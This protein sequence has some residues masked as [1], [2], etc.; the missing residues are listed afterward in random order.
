MSLSNT[1]WNI[2]GKGNNEQ[3]LKLL[4]D[5]IKCS[6]KVLFDTSIFGY[7]CLE[8]S[9][10]HGYFMYTKIILENKHCTS[11]F[12]LHKGRY[13]QNALMISCERGQY[14]CAKAIIE[15]KHC[16]NNIFWEVDSIG[17]NCLMTTLINKNMKIANLI[18]E[19]LQYR[20]I[21]N[22]MMWKQKN[23]QELDILT[24][25]SNIQEISK[26]WKE[27]IEYIYHIDPNPLFQ[28]EEKKRNDIYF[29]EI[30][31]FQKLNQRIQKM[32]FE[33]INNKEKINQKLQRI[34]M[35]LKNEIDQYQTQFNLFQLENEE[36]TKYFEIEKEEYILLFGKKLNDINEI[37]AK[38]HK[39]TKGLN[40]KNACILCYD[41]EKDIVLLPCSH[42]AI[43]RQC[44]QF[45]ND[46]CPIC[47]RKIDD[48]FQIYT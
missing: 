41:N 43:C 21:M 2:C 12:L 39:I 16:T 10:L 35:D 31:S 18:L 11:D 17:N 20:R 36:R 3:K 19:S 32:F 29:A 24:I 25:L 4:L 34:Q 5:D 48:S 44:K 42:L 28:M 9:C 23:H 15:S 47:R 14:E 22:P 27:Y 37:I 33:M 1:L 26:K 46:L 40:E 45:I 38:H 30:E 8:E 6:T 13:R 7:T